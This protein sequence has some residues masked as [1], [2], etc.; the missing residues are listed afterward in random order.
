MKDRGRGDRVE[1]C[2][3]SWLREVRGVA[4]RS[5]ASNPRSVLPCA[6]R[7]RGGYLF[8][9]C[10]PAGAWACSGISHRR[11]DV[12]DQEIT[13]Y[14]R[15]SLKLRRRM[16]LLVLPPADIVERALEAVGP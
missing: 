2:V 6:C 4:G 10:S 1:L 8:G 9:R 7:A 16:L 14:R 12:E 5:K 3:C 15:R 13:T 11:H